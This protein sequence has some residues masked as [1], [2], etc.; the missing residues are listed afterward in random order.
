M[1]WSEIFPDVDPRARDRFV[2][3]HLSNLD[4]YAEFEAS[5]IKMR[6]TGRKKYSAWTI[7]Q[8]IRWGRDVKT[9]GAVFKINN[10]HIA[11]YARLLVHNQP[12][13]DGF[14]DLRSMKMVRHRSTEEINRLGSPF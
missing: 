3:F 12:D 11:F 5:A 14:F 1:N 6:A 2:A 4:V 13:F 10:D 9:Q 8:A 7:I